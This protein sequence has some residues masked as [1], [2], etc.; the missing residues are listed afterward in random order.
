MCLDASAELLGC[1]FF[2]VTVQRINFAFSISHTLGDIISLF[3]N[4]SCTLLYSMYCSIEAVFFMSLQSKSLPDPNGPLVQLS[5]ITP[6]CVQPIP[7]QTIMALGLCMAPYM[8]VSLNRRPR[9]LD[10]Q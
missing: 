9:L 3:M 10:T 4:E 5:E 6:L 7:A 8:K 2:G 1:H